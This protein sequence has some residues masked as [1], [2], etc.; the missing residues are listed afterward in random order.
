MIL[1]VAGRLTLA[2]V[3]TDSAGAFR[4]VVL[5]PASTAVGQY[6]LLAEALDDRGT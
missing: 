5:I 2:E 3:P 6:R 1:G 4:R